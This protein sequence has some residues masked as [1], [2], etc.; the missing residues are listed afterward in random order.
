M[1][2][3]LELASYIIAEDIDA[4]IKREFPS[5][6]RE[7]LGAS[8]IGK[9]C[10]RELWYLFRWVAKPNYYKR[11]DDGEFVDEAPRMQRLFQRGHAEEDRF[12]SYLR[13]IGV[14]VSERDENGNQHRISGV[15][16]H[17]GGSMDSILTIPPRYFGNEMLAIGEYKTHGKKSFEKLEKFGLGN[18]IL[19]RFGQP[20]ASRDR[21]KWEHVV[22]MDTYGVAK[23]IHLGLYVACEKDTDAL[24]IRF[25]KLDHENGQNSLIKAERIVRSNRPPERVSEN[26]TSFKC[27]FCDY[28]DQCHNGAKPSEINCRSCRHFEPVPDA[29]WYCHVHAKTVI[30]TDRAQIQAA[31]PQYSPIA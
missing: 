30:T 3:T 18:L 17:F 2:T 28:K 11:N 20:Y 27:K 19:D 24:H 22:Q 7:H 26:P 12:I 25:R 13:G 5:E 31:C 14:Q 4:W 1:K 23:G 16:G 15:G 29:K 9:E 10:E 8:V 6:H 21:V